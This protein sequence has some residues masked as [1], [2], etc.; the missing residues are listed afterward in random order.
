MLVIFL[1]KP[2]VKDLWIDVKNYTLYHQVVHA[3]LLVFICKR[4]LKG[5]LLTY[6][7]YY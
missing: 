5:H 7:H 2:F 6:P 3:V 4:I 1:K